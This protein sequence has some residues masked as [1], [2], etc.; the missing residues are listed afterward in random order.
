NETDRISM[1]CSKLFHKTYPRAVGDRIVVRYYN[2]QLNANYYFDRKLD[3]FNNQLRGGGGIADL[4]EATAVVLDDEG[5]GK[6][7]LGFK[8]YN[9]TTE[10]YFDE[11]VEAGFTPS[12][13][14]SQTFPPRGYPGEHPTR[15]DVLHLVHSGYPRLVFTFDDQQYLIRKAPKARTGPFHVNR[16]EMVRLSTSLTDDLAQIL[17]N[18][19]L[20][21]FLTLETQKLTEKPL[22]I[23]LTA[24][25]ALAGPIASA[26]HLDFRGAYGD[27]YREL[28]FHVPFRIASYLNASQLFEDATWWYERIFD[29]TAGETPDLQKPADRYWR[30]IEFRDVTPP[31]MKAILSDAAAIEAYKTDPFN[32]F[33]IARLRI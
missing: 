17:F 27:Y 11:T 8:S 29:P 32:P 14:C 33:A 26:E 18:D 24:P 9:F 23:T 30:Y 25:Y 31:T 5:S 28:F 16:W 3:L 1:E 21:V 15:Q 6:A 2:R 13:L 12:A 10:A 4:D 19:G 22:G 7:Q 20:E